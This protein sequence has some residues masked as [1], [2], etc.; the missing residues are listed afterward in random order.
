M[1]ENEK[2]NDFGENIISSKVYGS[3]PRSLELLLTSFCAGG[4]VMNYSKNSLKTSEE[5]ILYVPTSNGGYVAVCLTLGNEERISPPMLQAYYHEIGADKIFGEN[6]KEDK[7]IAGSLADMCVKNFEL[8]NVGIEQY[9]NK[10]YEPSKA[11]LVEKIT[12]YYPLYVQAVKDF[13]EN[14]EKSLM[15]LS[16]DKKKQTITTQNNPLQEQ[17]AMGVL[18]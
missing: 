13:L 18:A 3:V 1:A 4:A 9:V 6:K 17:S 14:Y 2:V 10:I 8:G 16:S 7:A 11:K 5:A 15:A 12:V